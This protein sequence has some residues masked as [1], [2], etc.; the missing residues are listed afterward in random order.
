MITENRITEA[1]MKDLFIFRTNIDNKSEFLS[2]K[3][4]IKK[5]R[6]AYSCTIDLDDR[7]KVLRVE[8]EN[9]DLAEIVKEVNNHGF[10]CEELED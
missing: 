2:L 6:G 1:K 7:D 8:C 4:D 9:L 10:F 3:R 5:I